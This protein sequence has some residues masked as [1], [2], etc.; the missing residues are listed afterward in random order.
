MGFLL[1]QQDRASLTSMLQLPVNQAIMHDEVG[2][3]YNIDHTL[4]IYELH[5]AL[6]FT[7]TPSALECTRFAQ[8]NLAIAFFDTLDT[9]RCLSSQVTGRASV[10][11][12]CTGKACK[13]QK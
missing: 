2:S 3:L 13:Q 7:T 6:K 5:N 12:G 9:L 8:S 4:Q 1:A 10:R 11:T